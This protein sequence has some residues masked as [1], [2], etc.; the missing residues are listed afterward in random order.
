MQ[1]SADGLQNVGVASTGLAL[2]NAH[3]MHDVF[4]CMQPVC[5]YSPFVAMQCLCMRAFGEFDSKRLENTVL[6]KTQAVV[7]RASG[8]CMQ[9]NKQHAIVLQCSVCA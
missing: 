7:A 4:Y 8:A 5:S 3:V 2:Q 6:H 9:A 1:I